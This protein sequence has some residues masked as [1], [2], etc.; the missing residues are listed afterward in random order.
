L[1]GRIAGDACC[2]PPTPGV[3]EANKQIIHRNAFVI[4]DLVVIAV[5]V[6]FRSS[7]LFPF[8][9]RYGS[10]GVLESHPSGR[11]QQ[12]ETETNG[13]DNRTKRT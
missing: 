6:R 5:P 11:H 12:L 13:D 10:I 2:A 7:R 1:N 3:N 9:S 4:D 8:S